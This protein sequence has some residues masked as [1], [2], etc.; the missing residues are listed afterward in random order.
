MAGGNPATALELIREGGDVNVADSDGNTA[1]WVATTESDVSVVRALLEAGAD[2]NVQSRTPG[3]YTPLHMAAS[4]GLIEAA[5]VLL[6]HGADVTIRNSQ[7]QTALDVANKKW[8]AM[9]D[10]LAR[11]VR[12]AR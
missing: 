5:E 9:R 12:T 8:P 1:L 2:P 3:G 10:L 11:H 4:N 6:Q 7:G